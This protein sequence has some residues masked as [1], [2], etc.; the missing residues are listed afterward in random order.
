ML[1]GWNLMPGKTG[2]GRFF[3]ARNGAGQGGSPRSG[4]HDVATWRQPVDIGIP[5]SLHKPAQPPTRLNRIERGR[6]GGE[7]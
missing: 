5:L 1:G 2:F 7:G 3:C 4:R 6:A